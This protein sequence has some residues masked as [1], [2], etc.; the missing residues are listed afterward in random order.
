MQRTAVL[1]SD[2]VKTTDFWDTDLLGII[3]KSFSWGRCSLWGSL[4]GVDHGRG[5]LSRDKNFKGHR[6]SESVSIKLLALW[7]SMD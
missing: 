7:V 2:T 3:V 4:S 5:S 1:G 6:L